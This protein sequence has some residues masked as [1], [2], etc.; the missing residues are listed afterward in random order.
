MPKIVDHAERRATIARAA[1]EAIARDGIEGATLARVG[2]EAGLT[3][4]AIQHY[5]RDKDALL[6]AALRCTYDEQIERMRRRAA[7]H[8]GSLLDVMGEALPITARSRRTMRVWLAFWGRAV[9]HP[10]TAA[11]QRAIHDE[12]SAR[13]RAELERA[14]EDGLLCE[15]IDVEAEGLIAH[16]RGICICALL[17]PGAWRPKRQLDLLRCYLERLPG[18]VVAAP[19]PSRARA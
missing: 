7:R 5:F 9:G 2:R 13:V 18:A 3:T 16:I 8:P 12:W 4:G 19:R 17:D 11:A 14:V 10:D 6:A 1:C 15:D